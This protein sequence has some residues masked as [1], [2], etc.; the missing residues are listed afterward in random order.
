M[1]FSVGG[2]V[3]HSVGDNHGAGLEFA[4]GYGR[5]FEFMGTAQGE[6]F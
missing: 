5:E 3:H 6:T 4:D 2:T 1:N